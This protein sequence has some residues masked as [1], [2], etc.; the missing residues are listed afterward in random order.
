MRNPTGVPV[1][2]EVGFSCLQNFIPLPRTVEAPWSKLSTTGTPPFSANL[3]TCSPSQK[4]PG[5]WRQ[6]YESMKIHEYSLSLTKPLPS[7]S[8]QV[9]WKE[10]RGISESCQYAKRV[11][12]ISIP[13]LRKSSVLFQS[14]LLRK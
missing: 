6:H 10:L 4:V 12:S 11:T 9:N 5:K 1:S 2:Q 14:R 7:P 3:T 13:F 8:F